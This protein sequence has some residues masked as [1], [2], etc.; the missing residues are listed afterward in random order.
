MQP[1]FLDTTFTLL[2][3]QGQPVCQN[4]VKQSKLIFKNFLYLFHSSS[5]LQ[6]LLRMQY[7]VNEAGYEKLKRDSAQKKAFRVGVEF[8][9]CRFYPGELLVLATVVQTILGHLQGLKCIQQMLSS[10]VFILPSQVRVCE[11]HRLD[12]CI[13]PMACRLQGLGNALWLTRAN[14]LY[15]SHSPG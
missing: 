12:Q 11:D 2:Q 10:T 13:S 3:A 4:F 8:T 14:K 5:V 15:L 9:S 1:R 6:Y 7:Y